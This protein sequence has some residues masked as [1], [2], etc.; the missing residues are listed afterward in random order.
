MVNNDANNPQ[1][2][3]PAHLELGLYEVAKLMKNLSSELPEAYEMISQHVHDS[4]RTNFSDRFFSHL[5]P[6][7][8]SQVLIF[9]GF[10]MELLDSL[11]NLFEHVMVI[12]NNTD[13]D[14]D[15]IKANYQDHKNF[16]VVRPTAAAD[17]VCP[18]T[19]ILVPVYPLQ[20]GSLLAYNYPCKLL[21][22]DAKN[23]C[24]ALVAIEMCAPLPLKYG[25]DFSGLTSVLTP[26]NPNYITHLSRYSN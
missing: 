17:I 14:F 5:S 13:A 10:E 1:N 24:F 16:Q 9:C 15:R 26:I 7:N 11:S 23:S 8:F 12:P 22:K 3:T 21:T 2:I 20:D 18:D 19:I 4:D 25:Y 6:K